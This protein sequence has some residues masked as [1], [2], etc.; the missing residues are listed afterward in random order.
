MITKKYKILN[1][2]YK[3]KWKLSIGKGKTNLS[4]LELLNNYYRGR[5]AKFVHGKPNYNQNRKG[6]II[7]LVISL[8]R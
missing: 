8:C 2:E 1:D 6:I 4:H 5:F 7:F 3:D